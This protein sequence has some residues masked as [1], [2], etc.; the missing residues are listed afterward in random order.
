MGTFQ[1]TGGKNRFPP[2]QE[3][4]IVCDKNAPNIPT[5]MHWGEEEETSNDFGLPI[6]GKICKLSKMVVN[7]YDLVYK[8]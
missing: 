3:I 8:V 7:M 5:Y 1:C 6:I 4:C 2:S